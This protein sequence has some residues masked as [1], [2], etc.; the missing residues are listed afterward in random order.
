M[1]FVVVERVCYDYAGGLKFI[2]ESKLSILELLVV[3]EE[4]RV[5]ANNSFYAVVSTSGAN[6]CDAAKLVTSQHKFIA[7]KF[8]FV[9]I[10]GALRKV[11]F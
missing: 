9:E 11:F 7:V 5:E 6:G 2:L 8:C 1:R 10:E 4:P 3:R